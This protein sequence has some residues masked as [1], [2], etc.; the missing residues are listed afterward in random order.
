MCVEP[1]R[2]SKNAPF[3][4]KPRATRRSPSGGSE[5]AAEAE[6]DHE[7]EADGEQHGRDEGGRPDRLA[8]PNHRLPVEGAVRD[9]V[10]R[11]EERVD[12]DT[13]RAEDR[14]ELAAQDAAERE[15]REEN[16]HQPEVHDGAGERDVPV[17]ARRQPA[18]MVNRPRRGEN[19]PEERAHHGQ[20]QHAVVRAELRD[21]VVVDRD[22]LVC[23]LV[24]EE[25]DPRGRER[26]EQRREHAGGDDPADPSRAADEEQRERHAEREPRDEQVAELGP[27]EVEP[28]D[29]ASRERCAAA[30]ASPPTAP[31]TRSAPLSAPSTS[32]RPTSSTPPTSAPNIAGIT[33]AAKRKLAT[34]LPTFVIATTTM[35]RNRGTSSIADTSSVTDRVSSPSRSLSAPMSATLTVRLRSS[36]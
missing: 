24:E 27:A 5:R 26:D 35:S 16:R 32:S 3:R 25:A 8:P 30:H 10:E 11:R 21:L 7:D 20:K 6:S 18:A 22:D 33:Y 23:H 19:E 2:R 29:P 15:Q 14:D 31:R 13:A 9:Q 12:R 4:P 34:M 1:R 28:A 17:F 36:T